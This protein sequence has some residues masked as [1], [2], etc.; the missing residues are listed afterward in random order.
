MGVARLPCIAK[1]RNRLLLAV[2]NEDRV[3][4]E[5][6][7]S[8][9]RV[10]DPAG[11][12]PRSANLV[13]ARRESDELADVARPASVAADSFELAHQPADLVARSAPRGM[14]SGRTVQP[15]DLEAGVFTDHPAIA[16]ADAPT[17]LSFRAR[18][19]VIR[20]AVLRGKVLG[21]ER[22]DHPAGKEP[23]ELARLVRVARAKRRLHSDHRPSETLGTSASRATTCGG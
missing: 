4:A 17:E 15:G 13:T 22:F 16:R 20:R 5:A 18:V 12:R 6:L 2:G 9:G 19:V 11:E 3:E 23:L 7:A 8:A 10:R 14:H 21:V 1:L